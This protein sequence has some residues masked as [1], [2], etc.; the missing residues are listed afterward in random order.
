M[1]ADLLSDPSDEIVS[2]MR[3]DELTDLISHGELVVQLTS[4]SLL[5]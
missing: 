4:P 5:L 1:I 3:E 2:L